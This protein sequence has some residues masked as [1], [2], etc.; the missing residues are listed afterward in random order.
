MLRQNFTSCFAQPHCSDGK[1]G[2]G[3]IEENADCK[4]EPPGNDTNRRAIDESTK[5]VRWYWMQVDFQ[6]PTESE[7]HENPQ[8]IASQS[9]PHC[10]PFSNSKMRRNQVRCQMSRPGIVRRRTF[11]CQQLREIARF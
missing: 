10:F 8:I 6:V 2:D 11:G 1:Y 7:Q 3:G 4:N 5:V 9:P